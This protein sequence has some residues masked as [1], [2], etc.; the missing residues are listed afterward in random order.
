RQGHL[1]SGSITTSSLVEFDSLW[2]IYH[3]GDLLVISE[4]GFLECGRLATIRLS[5]NQN[6]RVPYYF[7]SYIQKNFD[8]KALPM[9]GRCRV[10]RKIDYFTGART[11]GSLQF[12]PLRLHPGKEELATLFEARKARYEELIG[13]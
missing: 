13:N 12:I 9:G 1:R 11:V 7:L 5:Y 4:K 3:P 10:R 2:V 6:T 8:G